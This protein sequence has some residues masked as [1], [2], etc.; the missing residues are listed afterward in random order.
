MAQTDITLLRPHLEHLPPP[1]PLPDGYALQVLGQADEPALAELLSLVFEETWDEA[2]VQTSLT[3]TADVR[4]VYGVLHGEV[5]VATASSQTRPQ[6]DP[7][8][9]FVHLVATHPDH[10][11]KGL[12][13]ALLGRVLEDFRARGDLRARLDTQAER[14]PAIRTYLRFGF[15]PEYVHVGADQRTVWSEI[16]QTLMSR[17]R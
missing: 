4:A 8:A 3:R 11:G 17:A 6:R 16:F 2:R 1:R 12:A 7:G 9:G 14:L 5:L 10:R 15:T 13:A